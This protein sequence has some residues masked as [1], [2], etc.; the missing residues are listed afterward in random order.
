MR[1]NHKD[2]PAVLVIGGGFAGLSALQALSRTRAQVTLV[3]RN[4]YSTFQPL[5]Y[6]VATAGLTAA[7]VAYPLWAATGRRGARYRK[8]ELAKLD[9]ERRVATLAAGEQLSYD[10]LIIATGVTA[11]FFGVDGAAEHSL[12]LYTRRDAVTLRNQL[13]EELEQRNEGLD[14]PELDVTVVGGGATGVELAGTLAE[15]R[16]FALHAVFPQVDR[17]MFVVRLIEMAP[18]LLA[19][20][21]DKL[22]QYTHDQLV[23]RGVDVR[24]STTI[25]EVRPSSVLLGDGSELRSDI[26]VW[27]AGIAGPQADWTAGLPHGKGGR[28]E[29]GPDLR[30]TGQDRVFAAGDISINQE[31]P[32]AQLAQP[33]LQQGRH[34]AEQII[35]LIAGRPT[36]PFRYHDKGTMATIGRRSAVVQLHSGLRLRGTLAW[37]AWL[38]LHLL[39]LLGNRNRVVT[40]VNLAW[41]YLTWSRGG[42]VIIGDDVPGQE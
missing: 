24:L 2:G 11:A 22:R 41:R 29:V 25:K 23:K 28:I 6:Q 42:G 21:N 3:D 31:D 38:G 19:P 8:G 35:R 12:S 14:D 7:D 4:I 20:Y 18:V 34:A 16:N 5:L 27:A 36:T 15:L 17:S 30:V 26:T 1:A 9:L 32:V 13:M 37:F 39:Y 40:L 33:A 10:Y